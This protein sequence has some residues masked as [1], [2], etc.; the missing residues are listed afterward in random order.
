VSENGVEKQVGEGANTQIPISSIN[1]K[2]AN[3]SIYPDIKRREAFAALTTI[4]DEEEVLLTDDDDNVL[5]IET[6]GL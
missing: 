3:L 2:A 4:D 1:L 6:F 5:T